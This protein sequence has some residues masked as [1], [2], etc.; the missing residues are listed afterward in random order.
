MAGRLCAAMQHSDQMGCGPC[1][2]VWDMNDP[3]PPRCPRE[4]VTDQRTR[5]VL[6]VATA[7]R[8][9]P[10]TFMQF[11]SKRGFKLSAY[12]RQLLEMLDKQIGH[13]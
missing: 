8:N 2:L 1:Q 5:G 4:P 11:A 13:S 7:M 10:V 12:Q 6:N 3:D 9:D